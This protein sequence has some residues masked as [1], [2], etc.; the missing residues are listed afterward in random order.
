MHRPSPLD[1]TRGPN[2]EMV[3]KEVDI[4]YIPSRNDKTKDEALESTMD[5]DI[6]LQDV[7]HPSS[8]RRFKRCR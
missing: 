5:A 6:W 1:H 7:K 8:S 2:V 3:S 4:T